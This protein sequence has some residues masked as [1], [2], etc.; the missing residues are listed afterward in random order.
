MDIALRDVPEFLVQRLS[1]RAASHRRSLQGEIMALL[2]EA[3]VEDELLTPGQVLDRVR[4]LGIHTPAESA[5]FVR[6]DRDSH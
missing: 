6:A 5:T 2:E 1:E 3:V 4:R